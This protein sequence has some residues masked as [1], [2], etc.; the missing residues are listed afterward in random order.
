MTVR[1]FSFG[2]GVQSTAALVLQAQGRIDFPLFIFANVGADSEAPATLRYVEEVA[3]P[4]AADRGIELVEVSASETL[5]GRIRRADRS[6]PIPVRMANGAPGNRQCTGSFKIRPVAAELRRRGA[7][8][9]DPAIVGLGISVDEWH[10]ART[11]SGIAHERLAYPLLDLRLTR[12]DCARVIAEAG[13]PVPPK[14][15]CWFCPYHR[16][17]EWQRMRSEDPERFAEVVTIERLLRDRRRRLGKDE[18]WMTDALRPID[19]AVA[20]QES[21]GWPDGNCESGYCWT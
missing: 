9:R 14:S 20:D 11:D 10:R 7:T 8:R 1:A 3:R 6:V 19:E 12:A 13:L 5:L 15:A 2:G 17:A 16:A 21:F 18:V 4:F